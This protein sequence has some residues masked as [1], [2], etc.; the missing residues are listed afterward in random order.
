MGVVLQTYGNVFVNGINFC[1]SHKQYKT[2]K[3]MSYNFNITKISPFSICGMP[4]EELSKY[5]HCE[6]TNRRVKIDVLKN[7]E[8]FIENAFA[9]YF[10]ID[11]TCALI[12]LWK[13]NGQFYS[14]M[15]GEKTDFMDDYYNNAPETKA[16]Y[17][18]PGVTGFSDDLR[19]QYDL[20]IDTILKYYDSK[21]IIL[22]KSHMSRFFDKNGSAD[23]GNVSPITRYFLSE[24]DKYFALK[25]N[26]AVIDLADFFIPLDKSSGKFSASFYTKLENEIIAICEMDSALRMRADTNADCI[27][28]NPSLSLADYIANAKGKPPSLSLILNYLSNNQ[29]TFEDIV[30]LFWLYEKTDD[31]AMFKYIAQE[32]FANKNGRAYLKTKE[33]FAK[34]KALLSRYDYCMIE[35]ISAISF[36]DQIVIQFSDRLYL[37]ITADGK[38]E[39]IQLAPCKKWNWNYME[40][41]QSNNVCNIDEIEDALSSCALYFERARNNDTSP[42]KLQFDNIDAFA[43]SLYYVDYDDILS[44]ENYCITL[45]GSSVSVNYTP[46]VNLTFLF[47]PKTRI[48]HISAGLG[49]QTRYYIYTEK[50]SR[51][52]PDFNIYV[53]DLCYDCYNPFNGMEIYTFIG[54]DIFESKKHRY[55]RNIFS[56]KMRRQFKEKSL[57]SKHTTFQRMITLYLLGLKEAVVVFTRGKVSSLDIWHPE[58]PTLSSSLPDFMFISDAHRFFQISIDA[59]AV[60][61]SR[62]TS[63]WY[64]MDDKHFWEEI[65]NFPPIEEKDNENREMEQ[66]MLSSDACVLHIRRGDYVRA[67]WAKNIAYYKKY[68]EGAFAIEEYTNKHLFVFSDDIDWVRENANALAINLFG[69]EVTYMN[70]NH[71][72]SSFR[73]M[74]LMT[75]G[76]V[77]ILGGRSGFSNTAA[78]AS[79]RVEYIFGHTLAPKGKL[80][81]KRKILP[82][83]TRACEFTAE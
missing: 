2:A 11:N 60:M 71:H 68:I 23:L 9:D 21:H 7:F 42:L 80:Y 1:M 72:Y 76:K 22:V 67:K 70:N 3:D 47:D 57:E 74:Q 69:D 73:D 10:V 82:D 52:Y 32:I 62:N 39:K 30:A 33:L 78:M 83:G 37:K 16:N 24:L 59:P 64:N 77:I 61:I 53:Y 43:D 15:G 51:E 13:I 45:P 20:F 40:F 58:K 5:A 4:D 49:D 6:R 79:K 28:K 25:T 31:K 12:G 14:L 46:K 41:I 81:T 34:N 8:E 63:I 18:K 65:C 26:C 75:Y 56:Y 29:Y 38:F 66:K 55:F 36:T 19:V 35:E 54:K 48:T 17:I 44:N 50:M 27:F